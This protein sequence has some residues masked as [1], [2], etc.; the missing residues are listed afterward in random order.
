MDNKPP[1]VTGL[2][3]RRVSRHALMLEWACRVHTDFTVQ[4]Y[5]MSCADGRE[6]GA[7][8]ALR[9]RELCAFYVAVVHGYADPDTDCREHEDAYATAHTATQQLTDHMDEVIGFPLR[10]RPD[11]A[12]LAPAFFKKFH[13][14]AMQALTSD[15]PAVLGPVERQVRPRAWLCEL[16]QDD[17]TTRT[18][19]V[20]RDPAG[21]RWNDAGEPSPYRT[22]PLLTMEQAAQMVAS[23]RERWREKVREIVMRESVASFADAATAQEALHELVRFGA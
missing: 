22:T 17:G 5:L 1:A 9:H 2:D 15:E 23:E 19:F 14:L 11:Y 10:G 13:A 12:T 3:E 16:A 21:L 7:E 8:K 6:D 20:E 4:R 18:Q